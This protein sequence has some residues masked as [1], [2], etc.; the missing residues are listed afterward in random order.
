MYCKNCGTKLNDNANFC[1]KCGTPVE[2]LSA[3]QTMPQQQE[4]SG[5]QVAPQQIYSYEQEAKP[6]QPFS[7]GQQAA[8]QQP[9]AYGQQAA[10]QQT[11]SYEK[12]ETF[13]PKNEKKTPE[14]GITD[15]SLKNKTK[16]NPNEGKGKKSK[17]PIVFISIFIVLIIGAGIVGFILLKGSKDKETPANNDDIRISGNEDTDSEEIISEIL[18]EDSFDTVT[19]GSEEALGE[20]AEVLEDMLGSEGGLEQKQTEASAVSGDN[21]SEE[22][23]SEDQDTPADGVTEDST[24]EAST[25]TTAVTADQTQTE[26]NQMRHEYEI[27]MEDITWEEAYNKCLTL[28]GHLVTITTPEEQEKIEKMLDT[29]KVKVVMLGSTDYTPDGSY[30]WTNGEEFK[31]SKWLF[32]EPNNEEDVEHYLYLYYVDDMWQWN[33]APN[34]VIQ[35]YSGKIA[36][37]CEWEYDE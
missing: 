2:K 12:G 4:L 15:H 33:D 16:S 5:Q 20:A 1:N 28:G 6:Q 21:S 3:E 29:K 30:Q 25:G 37:I 23:I 26:L 9:Y 7:Y 27:Y 36:Y 11:Y 19:E 31:Y 10:P 17:L 13:E 34:D 18:D 14:V 24:A 8:P 22:E 35:Y 32:G